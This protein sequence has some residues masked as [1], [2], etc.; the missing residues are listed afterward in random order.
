[1]LKNLL[2]FIDIFWLDIKPLLLFQYLWQD[3]SIFLFNPP[4]LPTLCGVTFLQGIMIWSNSNLHNQCFHTS[5]III[6]FWLNAFPEDFLI[7]SYI[8][9]RPPPHCGST[10]HPWI[11]I[12]RNLNLPEDASTQFSFSGMLVCLEDFFYI[13]LCKDSTLI[14]APPYPRGPWF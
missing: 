14:V 13:F 4:P 8:K 10:L 5:F 2:F 11:M 9:I 12:L 7:Y 6:I 3:F 1:M